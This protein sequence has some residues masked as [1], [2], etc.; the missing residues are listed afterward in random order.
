MNRF[1]S[2]YK[3]EIEELISVCHRLGELAYTVSSGGNISYRVDDDIVLITPSKT[4]KRTMRPEE[5]C[6]IKMNGDIL[7]LPNGKNLT[8]EVH[9]HLGIMNDRKDVKAIIHAHPPYLTGFALIDAEVLDKP[10]LPEVMMEIGPIIKVPY[11]L[12]G[13]DLL[14]K[15]LNNHIKDSNGFILDNHGAVSCSSNSV[16]EAM[17]FMQMMET[18]A[19]SVAVAKIFSDPKTM[20]NKDMEDLDLVI[21]SR[22]ME[23]PGEVGKFSSL[24][25]LFKESK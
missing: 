16:F 10:L 15:A 11:I 9:L 18:T 14:A 7:F 13:T 12:P 3:K 2:E 22:E 1:Q 19:Q 8:S 4:P 6:I 23:L 21:Q 24:S 25:E 5:I 17:E 20:T